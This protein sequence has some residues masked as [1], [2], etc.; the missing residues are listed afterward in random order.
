[1]PRGQD[2]DLSITLKFLGGRQAQVTGTAGRTW[3]S[4]LWCKTS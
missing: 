4:M 2:A 3:D 1:L